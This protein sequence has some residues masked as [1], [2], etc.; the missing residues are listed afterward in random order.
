MKI[1]TFL[2]DQAGPAQLTVINPHKWLMA[3]GVETDYE[4][5]LPSDNG[6][7]G[8][9]FNALVKQ[10]SRYDLIIVQRVTQ[11]DIMKMIRSA[12]D[13]LGKPLLLILD[14]DYIHL[15][16]HNPCHFS[17]ALGG[18]IQMYRQLQMEGK[19]E[20]ANALIPLLEMERV[21]GQ[22]ELKEAW[23]MPDHVIVTTEELADVVRPYNRNI[24]VFCNNMER[25]HW[26]TDLS[27]EEAGPDGMLKG[28]SNTFGLGTIPSYYSDNEGKLQKVVRIGY[29]GTSTH[30]EDYKTI[31]SSLNKVLDKYHG[32]IWMVYIGDP[33]FFQR[34][35]DHCYKVGLGA[36][37]RTH[38]IPATPFDTY[39][40]NVRN[41]DIGLAPL[42][43]TP[44][45]M[46]K[47]DLK[48]LEYS[49]W[50]GCS[51]LPHYVTYS[52]SFIHKETALL[53]RNG[54]EFERYLEELINNERLRKKL[55]NNARN[56]IANNRLEKH[57]SLRRY[58]L[59]KSLIAASPGLKIFQ[60]EAA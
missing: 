3:Y 52:R 10:I 30:Q 37:K 54:E 9:S 34:R 16:R 51:L 7:P 8:S 15:E 26:E 58:E 42:E 20:E 57:H 25:V 6:V 11:L 60:P 12:C 33:W 47:S 4:C 28:T 19:N 27:I 39:Q 35:M 31:E 53:Y 48:A 44:F 1:L 2:S 24:S 38:F 14:D 41:I 36:Q 5:T 40:L 45:N 46:S 49:A 43:P 17:T 59:Y 18:T 32:K 21:K 29:T 55:G 23:A 13:L 50:S 56:Y 22:Q